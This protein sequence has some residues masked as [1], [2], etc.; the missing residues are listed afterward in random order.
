MTAWDIYLWTRLDNISFFFGA[1]AIISIFVTSVVIVLY[2]A[3][4]GEVID[5]EVSKKTFRN[6]ILITLFFWFCGI[7]IPDT[8]EYAMIYV[9]PKIASQENLDTASNEMK[10]LYKIAKT[11]LIEKLSDKKESDTKEKE[12]EPK[13]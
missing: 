4:G 9:L 13:K 5:I 3:S 12:S 10:D 1:C 8:K 7:F 2:C 11:A 6:S